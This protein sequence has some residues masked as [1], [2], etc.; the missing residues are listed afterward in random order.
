[1]SMTVT[2]RQ[3]CGAAACLSADHKANIDAAVAL[4]RLIQRQRFDLSTEK[5]LQAEL[6][7][8]LTKE[9]IDFE[10]E[11]SLSEQDIP[12]FVIAGGIVIECKVRGAR[13]MD[14]YRQLCRYAALPAVSVIILASNIAMGLPPEIAGKPLYAAALSRGWI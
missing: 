9:G 13:K 8:V 5:R 12:D 4:V 10:R 14:V 2:D 7:E 1:M 11:K 6:A 3:E